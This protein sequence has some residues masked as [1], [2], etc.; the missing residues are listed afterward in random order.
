MSIDTRA[1]KQFLAEEERKMFLSAEERNAIAKGMREGTLQQAAEAQALRIAQT[2]EMRRK[3]AVEQVSTHIFPSFSPMEPEE[4]LS[5]CEALYRY[6]VDGET[7]NQGAVAPV[8]PENP[9]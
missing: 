3:W 5:W 6:L 9:A 7:K 4:F 2:N 1:D 8:P